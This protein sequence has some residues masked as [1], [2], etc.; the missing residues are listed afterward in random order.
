MAL[1][2]GNRIAQDLHMS[3]ASSSD[4]RPYRP[5]VRSLNRGSLACFP[6]VNSGEAGS[7]FPAEACPLPPDQNKLRVRIEAGEKGPRAAEGLKSP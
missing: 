1:A 6:G 5:E 7:Q 2:A 3:F 4:G